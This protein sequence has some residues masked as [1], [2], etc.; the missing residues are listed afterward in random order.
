LKSKIITG[1][2]ADIVNEND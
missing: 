1:C 2:P